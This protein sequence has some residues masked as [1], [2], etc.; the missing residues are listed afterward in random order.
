MTAK[1]YDEAQ[2]SLL[3]TLEIHCRSKDKRSVIAT[4]N[5]MLHVAGLS[6]S[7][8]LAEMLDFFKPVKALCLTY[9]AAKDL[10]AELVFKMDD[11]SHELGEFTLAKKLYVESLEFRPMPTR[12]LAK[13]AFRRLRADYAIDKS[14]FLLMKQIAATIRRYHEMWSSP[15]FE[16]EMPSPRMFHD[17]CLPE[18]FRHFSSLYYMLAEFADNRLG[19]FDS[20]SAQQREQLCSLF[21]YRNAVEYMEQYRGMN[22]L[23]L[24]QSSVVLNLNA[25]P[26]VLGQQL[27]SVV[28]DCYKNALK[29]LKIAGDSNVG[30]E[31]F[32]DIFG[33]LVSLCLRYQETEELTKILDK[34][35][36]RHYQHYPYQVEFNRQMDQWRRALKNALTER[37]SGAPETGSQSGRKRGAFL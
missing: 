17:S 15:D 19:Q 29:L 32:S 9:P 34:Q 24:N 22:F 16:D 3:T 26:H 36:Y 1:E 21:N 11:I 33:Q 2:K 27:V 23:S 35:N 30:K 5:Q 7:A 28:A 31:P 14:D 13:I 8:T 10:H 6:R 37:E 12:Y 20:M 25:A 18:F 4:L